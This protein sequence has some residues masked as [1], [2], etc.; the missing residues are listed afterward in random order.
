M[1]SRRGLGSRAPPVSFTADCLESIKWMEVSFFGLGIWFR[2]CE[3]LTVSEDTFVSPI[4]LEMIN[5]SYWS[6]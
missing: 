1:V 4:T 3:C 5:S 2:V 6:S